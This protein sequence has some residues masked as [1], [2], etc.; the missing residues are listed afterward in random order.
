MSD[1][2][3]LFI[4][5]VV[6][7]AVLVYIVSHLPELWN[8][9]MQG[10]GLDLFDFKIMQFSGKRKVQSELPVVNIDQL[11]DSFI[12]QGFQRK[13]LSPYFRKVR[14]SGVQPLN[15]SYQ[16]TLLTALS[17]NENINITG[18][19]L[20]TSSSQAYIPLAVSQ[21]NQ[22]GNALMPVDIVLSGFSIVNVNYNGQNN[23][24]YNFR[25]NKCSGYWQDVYL[26]NPPL[27]KMCP[28]LNSSEVMH[29]SG[30]CQDYIQSLSVCQVPEVSFYNT[31]GNTEQ[32]LNCRRF[33]ET[34]N[35]QGCVKKHY[36]DKDFLSNEW[37][38]WFNNQENQFFL[39]NLHDRVLLLDKNGLLVDV[40]AY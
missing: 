32:D 40:F 13:Q 20:K 16:I 27:P 3:K 11:P 19:V 22:L 18:W 33:L 36:L 30:V 25:L 28:I 29:L 17:E 7:V 39:D 35:Y 1:V 6:V 12:P 31:L 4:I 10:K 2:A 8:F 5:L 23:L 38:I 9:I 34:I 15:Y 26:F 14:I 21:Y 24:G 37:Y